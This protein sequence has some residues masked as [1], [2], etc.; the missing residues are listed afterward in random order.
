MF[1]WK[2]NESDGPRII[3]NVRLRISKY[4]QDPFSKKNQLSNEYISIINKKSPD[5]PGDFS[6]SYYDAQVCVSDFTD[7][8][9]DCVVV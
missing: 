5:Y 8:A 1:L 3:S 4:L 2:G 6:L 7:F 9:S